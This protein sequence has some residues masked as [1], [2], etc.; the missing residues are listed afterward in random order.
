MNRNNKRITPVLNTLSEACK[1]VSQAN[2][3]QTDFKHSES[4]YRRLFESSKDMI[5]IISREGVFLDINQAMVDLLEYKEKEA[6]LSLK[7][8]NRV[9]INPIHWHVCKKH[10]DQDGF[11]K[12]FEV[13]FKK[14]DGTRL[15]GNLSAN[16]FLDDHGNILGYEGIAKDITARMD[17]FRRLYKH[18]QELVLL[19]TIA[20]TMNSSQK[21]GD[22]LDTA[23]NKTMKLLNFSSGAI[24]LIN[25]NKV[26]FDLQT[27]KGLPD[28]ITQ[29][30]VRPV[31]YDHE[32]MEFFLGKDNRLTPKSIFPSFKIVLEDPDKSQSIILACFLITEKDHPSGFMAFPFE[33]TQDLALED[34]H[35]LGSLGNF[36]GGSIGN[37]KLLKTVRK[38]QDEL[39][40]LAAKLFHSQEFECRRIS[41]E[42][43]DETGSALIGINLNLEAVEKVIP[44]DKPA[45]KNIIDDIKRQVNHTYQEMRR[46]SHL[47]HPA[48][49]TDLGLEPALD[50]FLDE[51]AGQNNLKIDFKMI[52][53]AGRINPDIETVLYRFS[54]ETLSNTIKYAKASFFKLSIIK[55]YPSVIF[56]AEDDGIG[57]DPD[58]SNLERPALGLLSMKERAAILGGKFKLQ[59]KKNEGTRIRIEIPIESSGQSNLIENRPLLEDL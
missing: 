43:H 25:H 53:F 42:L 52:G 2:N 38:H 19:N 21:L 5:F 41:R 7:E 32:L 16:T 46:I 36:L 1:N 12:D 49:L 56:I 23:L 57:F 14:K 33:E 6:L 55:G 51:R 27:Q 18:H 40:R 29:K 50:A 45:V 4:I 11:I 59:T 24:F 30:P 28:Q 20:L 39:K 31:F 9:F 10:L 13:G 34:F 44:P 26:L 37:I 17:S 47:L 48:L 58:E 22:V 8:I 3:L 35:L 15:H 54:Q